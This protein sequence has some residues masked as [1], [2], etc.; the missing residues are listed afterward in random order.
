[1]PS[2]VFLRNTQFALPGQAAGDLIYAD[3][4][5]TIAG[6]ADV[7]TG[8]VLLSGGVGAAPSY[9]KVGLTTHISGVLPVANGGTNLASY[10]VGDLIYA[11][12]ATSLARL[13]D[14]ATGQVLA[15]GGVGV[16]P[17]YTGS[18]T[19]TLVSVG[20]GS[21]AAP[22]I[23]FTVENDLGC[24]RVGAGL[25]GF[26]DEG[27]G[28]AILGN[29]AT[30]GMNLGSILP[31]SWA[32]TTDPTAGSSDL[33]LFRDAANILAQRNGTSAQE[34]RPYGY[35]ASVSGFT[36]GIVKSVTG[37]V[38]LAGA[39]SATGNII[40]VGSFV[41]GVATTTT[42]TITGASGY[43]V[44]D[45]SDADRWGDITG[46]AVGT[47]SDNTDSTANPTGYFAAASAVTLT[48]KTSN[49]TGGVVQV[50]VFYLT[51][52]AD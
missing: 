39:T 49:F 7:A 18:P 38:T 29:A 44:G 22:S 12:G 4:A 48:A 46:T 17:A 31:V 1:M 27:A 33:F 36:S 43:Q 50:T 32:N 3:S 21:A 9:G 13:A 11:D 14:V 19:L 6:L 8:N 52:G 10:A 45:G 2:S 28:F 34:F 40:P 5:T 15:S 25:L 23:T 51:T 47:D 20:N 26:A 41:I 37:A 24:Y 42:T 16:A 35:F 30:R